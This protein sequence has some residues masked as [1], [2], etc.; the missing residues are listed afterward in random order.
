MTSVLI[1]GGA[2]FIGRHC[3]ETFMARGVKVRGLDVL[4]PQVHD[5]PDWSRA[6]FSGE[7]VEGDVRDV[8]IVRSALRQCDLVVHLAAE[9]GVGQ[10]MYE[11]DR[12]RSINVDG[13]RVVADCALEAG[14]PMINFSSRAVYGDGA[15]EC[16][17]CGPSFGRRLCP[18]AAPKASREDDPLL[19]TSVYGETKA[20]AERLLAH[21]RERGLSAIS[22]R[23][24]NVVGPGQALSNP[25]TGVLSAFASRVGERLSLL[26]YGDGTQTRDFIDVADVANVVGWL[27]E[28]PRDWPAA[29][30]LN[31]GSGHRTSLLELA[32]LVQ[33][34]SGAGTG[35]EHVDVKRAGDIQH[36][37]ADLRL[38]ES[39]GA[40]RASLST[41]D[42]V[43][44]FLDWAQERPPVSSEIWDH[45]LE[46]LRERK[47][48]S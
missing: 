40:P 21:A 15:F 1:T 20:E 38:F 2:G 10:S 14:V 39:I 11:V 34:I 46:E 25:Y 13:T 41:E 12:Y 16:E 27:A 36:A 28:R 43:R 37:C 7:L 35:I 32:Q 23:P 45:A 24:Q 6:A 18:T 22:L 31:V 9:T 19:P 17:V 5:D 3:A 33:E 29:G 47:M 4:N 8:D 26:V 48:L 44:R 30:A 42:A